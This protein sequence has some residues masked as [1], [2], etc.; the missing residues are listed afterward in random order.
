MKLF[1]IVKIIFLII[2]CST[3]FCFAD[4][5]FVK[6]GLNYPET[7]PYS[8]QG[9]DEWRATQIA[10]E[11][12]NSQGGILGKKIQI[13]KRDSKSNVDVSVR[14]ATELIDKEDIKMIFGGVSSGVAVAV[15]EIAQKKEVVF[16]ATVTASNA[17]TGEK[18]HRHTFRG[19]FNAWM[20]AKA[21]SKYLNKHRIGKKYFYITSNYTWGW[22]SEESI[23]KFTATNEKSIHKTALTPFPGA[24]ERDFKIA[25]A[26][27]KISKADILILVLFGDDMSTAIRLATEMGLKDQMEIVVPVLELNLA[28]KAGA[29][30]MS[31]VMGTSD[32]NWKVPYIY[33]Y[34]NGKAFVNKFLTKYEHYPCF[35]AA[36]AYTILWQYKHAVERAKSFDASS[37][38][39]SMENHEFTLLKDKS[40][41][42]DFDHQLISSVYVVRCYSEAEILKSK[43]Q[44]DYFDV[45]EKFPGEEMVQ[46]REEWNT[47]RK[48]AGLPIYLEKLPGE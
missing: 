24:K 37:V 34:E 32:W 23:R 4:Q 22:S 16:M 10:V 30:A 43:Y 44:L 9:L 21:L 28:Q 46:T 17:T 31:G 26:K 41:W 42:R 7:G 40:K 29:K 13:I 6:I 25:L 1:R 39:K 47:R 5:N 3:N 12:I 20:G 48:K 45:L 27:A 14:N 19:S 36:A 2:F 15:G 8:A 18:G 33:N 35:G 38:I 11:E